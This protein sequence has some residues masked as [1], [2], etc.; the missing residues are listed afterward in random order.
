MLFRRF[1]ALAAVALTA[2]L[3]AATASAKTVDL[4]F[5]IDGSGSVSEVNFDTTR[6][7][8]ALALANIP[9]SGPVT[10]R[11][12]VTQFGQTVETIVPVTVV[13]PASI[14]GIQT[15]VQG[16]VYQRGNQTRT[17]LAITQT[18]GLFQTAGLGDT[19][20]INITTDGQP[21]TSGISSTAAQANAEAAALTAFN[22]GLN[23]LSFE[24]VGNFSSTGLSNTARIAGLGTTGNVAGGTV[25]GA[26]DPIPN[27]TMTGFVIPVADF[28]SLT[29]AVDAKV[30]SVIVATSPVPLPAGFPLLA[31]GLGA[32]AIMRRRQAA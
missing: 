9:T 17:D 14:G 5:S 30:A 32:F 7:A 13:T 31:V 24:A 1:T 4:G 16:A 3:G 15:A 29:G 8:L 22:A 12:A 10:Y 21:F 11:V 27:P 6:N 25:L 20:L 23:G 28:A 2:I 18:F 19:T 26:M